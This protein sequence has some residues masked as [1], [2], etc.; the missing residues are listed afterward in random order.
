MTSPVLFLGLG[1]TGK[2]TLMHLRRLYLDEYASGDL[3][4]SVVRKYG[5]GRLPHT[6][7]LC[8]DSDE[9]L[10]DIDGKKFDELLLAAQLSGGEF[11][12]VEIQPEQVNRLYDQPE[13]HA[14]Y[15]PWYDFGLDKKGI[16]RNGCGQTRPWGRLAYFQNHPRIRATLRNAIRDL[17]N[18]DTGASAR[19]MGVNN[20]R[21]DR[22]EV[23]MVF[24]VAGGTGSGMFLDVSFLLRSLAEELKVEIPVQAIIVLPSVFG[25]DPSA[26]IFANGYAALME[27]EYY[28]LKREGADQAAGEGWFPVY[29]P[30]EYTPGQP[31]K[32]LRGPVFEAVWLIGDRSRGI[33]GKGDGATIRPNQK[34]ELT[35]MAAEWLFVRNSPNHGV[36]GSEIDSDASN[37]VTVQ[38][39]DLARLEVFEVGDH[40]ATRAIQMTCRYG[41]FGL[42]KIYSPTNLVELM[43]GHRLV[44]DIISQ[45]LSAPGQSNKIDEDM[46]HEVRPKVLLR[47]RSQDS[48]DL[49]DE[50]ALFD[51]VNRSGSG[52]ALVDEAS[53]RFN[54]DFD[55]QIADDAGTDLARV[56]HDRLTEHRR[57]NVSDAG[58]NPESHGHFARQIHT[59]M[60]AARKALREG[61]DAVVGE[62]LRDPGRRFVFAQEALTR[63]RKEFT[64]VAERASGRANDMAR[65]ASDALRDA[66]EVLRHA[67]TERSARVRRTIAKVAIGDH[68]EAIRCDLERQVYQAVSELAQEA[69]RL[70]GEADDGAGKAGGRPGVGGRSLLQQLGALR[71][72]LEALRDRIVERV[73]G[74][75]SRNQSILN[76]QIVSSDPET[77]YRD[78]NDAPIT[79]AFVR[80]AAERLYGEPAIFQGAA[81]TPWN[82]RGQLAGAAA[83]HLLDQLVE[84]GRVEMRHVT[85]SSE[86]VL[87][88]FDQQ[89][90]GTAAERQYADAMRPLVRSGTPWLA[91]SQDSGNGWKLA[92]HFRVARPPH[93]GAHTARLDNVF[94]NEFSAL[95]AKMIDG[96]DD[97]LYFAQEIAGF[98]LSVAPGMKDYRD[99]AYVPL[100]TRE[101][102]DNA[103]GGG[104]GGV[105]IELDTEKFIDLVEP[106][107]GE[108]S[109]R[110]AAVE[111]FMEALI[112]RK[113]KP[114][115]DRFGMIYYTVREK[116]AFAE[117]TTDLGR[118]DRAV[119]LF[120]NAQSPTTT[121]LTQQVQ[122]MEAAWPDDDATR[123]LK[124]RLL[125][126]LGYYAHDLR[127]PIR[128]VECQRSVFRLIERLQ[129]RWQIRDEE[130][131]GVRLDMS[132]AVEALPPVGDM[133]ASG[134]LM[135]PDLPEIPT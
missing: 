19:E 83:E 134:H 4:E 85:Q 100:I 96:T 45:W 88:L 49:R 12:K 8:L 61:L 121:Q 26:R 128:G 30:G 116:L 11:L 75:S 81:G 80:A 87:T 120:T 15:A 14:E 52:A 42:S 113:I 55:A 46:D 92:S 27:L 59:N 16:P 78:A 5:S 131:A 67:R 130:V 25:T 7:F 28:N 107:P 33:D 123:R 133:P 40:R 24:S 106:S 84:H 23:F 29:W 64:E 63:L 111:L 104:G 135:A 118:Y 99:R 119:R 68:D 110:A 72:G 66:E 95:N 9:R 31:P 73:K 37:Y 91:V 6:G 44:Q 101:M 115:R 97:T 127:R 69:A 77:F 114:N 79:P 51:I 48:R 47:L 90:T 65:D 89:F 13:R 124:I 103:A 76:L 50:D 22:V 10:E 70:I 86:D 98:P 126:L 21:T 117:F 129:S 122:A 102:S 60:E 53:S 57:R 2:Q 94:R 38:M 125:A 32:F 56:F 36:L 105:H 35:A 58:D 43:A 71:A 17:I 34:H 20:L 18:E 39:A 1:G 108:A 109:R 93:G 82:L 62:A 3:P 74:L 41:A 54:D 112:K 132:W